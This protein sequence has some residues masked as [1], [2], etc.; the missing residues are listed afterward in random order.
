MTDAAALAFSFFVPGD[1]VPWARAGGGKTGHRFTPP[2]QAKYAATLK[3]LCQQAM[4]GGKPLDGPIALRLIA[5]YPW[6]KSMS[7]KR[8]ASPGAQWRTSKPDVDNLAKIVGDA[9]NKVAWLDDAQI[10]ASSARKLY[11]DKPGLQVIVEALA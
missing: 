8:R 11:G 10:A 5:V 3:V 4:R 1:C 2:K 7:A 6:P 9:L